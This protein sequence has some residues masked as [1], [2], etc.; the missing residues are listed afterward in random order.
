MRHR[1]FR[2]AL[3]L[4]AAFLSLSLNGKV[5][6]KQKAMEF[7]TRFFANNAKSRG[8]SG[9]MNFVWDSNQLSSKTRSSENSPTFYV[10]TPANGEGFVIVAGDDASVPVLGYSFENEIPNVDRLPQNLRSWL[11][12]VHESITYSRL[13]GDVSSSSIEK[14]W[15]QSRAGDPLVLLETPTWN[16]RNPYNAQ[17][18][19]DGAER[20]LVGCTPVA[21]ATIM[22]YY[23]W[24]KAGKGTTEAYTTSTKGIRVGARN[25]E[26]QYDWDKMK[27]EYVGNSYTNEEANAVAILMADIAM[28][29][30]ADFTNESTSSAADVEV[31]YNHFDYHPGMY[32][33]VRENCNDFEEWKQLMVNELMKDRPILYSGWSSD[34]SRG[35]SFVLDG[36]TTDDYFH[37]NFGWGGYCDGYFYLDALT[38]QDGRDTDYSYNQWALLN[39]IPNDGSEVADQIVAYQSEIQSGITTN[40]SDF[41]PYT[42]FDVTACVQNSSAIEFKG[43]F[44]LAVTDSEGNIKEWISNEIK[45]INL[46][47]RYYYPSLNF[48]C[49]INGDIVIGD[50]IRMFYKKQDSEEWNLI[51]SLSSNIPWEILIMDEYTISESTS[52]SFDKDT[53][54]L[55]ISF[56]DNVAATMLRNGEPIFTGITYNQNSVEIETKNLPE[57]IY[58]IKLEKGFDVKEFDFEVKPL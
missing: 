50:R 11:E 20:A 25:L 48:S 36:C 52:V 4:L 19:M 55:L 5:V 2:F 12:G 28:G 39:M 37:I 34:N 27:M 58:T 8:A 17:C 32:W 38:P 42:S 47:P 54:I 9:D 33:A 35:H 46:K 24:P 22:R 7:A 1:L 6:T 56:K 26:H 44:R 13:Q 18:P 14:R 3:V 30:Q 15:T 21:I 29:I 16:Q 10:F 31:L 51:T 45:E 43:S 49:T 40:V 23:E 41:F 53:G 57:G